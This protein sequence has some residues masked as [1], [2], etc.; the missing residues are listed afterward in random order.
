M[1]FL[2]PLLLIALPLIAMPIVIHLMNQ[3][4]HLVVPWAAM[5]F[6]RRA[7]RLNTGVAK[8]RYW[9]IM[10]MRMAAVTGVILALSRPLATG[11]V[12]GLGSN[13]RVTLIVLDR[14]P[15]MELQDTTTQMSKRM[16]AL[17]RLDTLFA[18]T[19]SLGRR[20]LLTS[21]LEKPL[22]ITSPTKLSGL[23]ETSSVAA[24]SDIP[25]LL[26]KAIAFADDNK[27]GAADI[28]VASDLQSGDWQPS[29]DRWRAIRE[30]V[31]KRP[32]T[33]LLLLNFPNNG[34]T[35]FSVSA[36]NIKPIEIDGKT[37]TSFDI[38]LHQNSGPLVRRTV[39]VLVRMGDMQST[40]EV[41]MQGEDGSVTGV[42]VPM[43]EASPSHAGMLE[44][45]PDANLADNQFHFVSQKTRSR[46]AVVVGQAS[47]EVDLL[48]LALSTQNDNS[49]Q[50]NL[51]SID[52][53]MLPTIDWKSLKLL[54]WNQGNINSATAKQLE[55]FIES[56][57]TLVLFPPSVEANNSSDLVLPF[58]LQ[59]S[60]MEQL[61]TAE[62]VESWRT[63]SD[64]LRNTEGGDALP[65]G[66][67]RW[68]QHWSMNSKGLIAL[69]KSASGKPLLSKL[70]TSYGQLFVC[71]TS[72]SESASN[73][74]EDGVCLYIMLQ[75]A[76]YDSSSLSDQSHWTAGMPIPFALQEWTPANDASQK[77][78]PWERS[79]QSGAY[80]LE[81]NMIAVNR[82]V[83]ED[84]LTSL[85]EKTLENM[86]QGVTY[87]SIVDDAG[88]PNSL[89]REIW[90]VF[91]VGMILF[92]LM[93]AWLSMPNRVSRASVRENTIARRGLAA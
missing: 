73:L 60:P 24:S 29:S 27:L 11:W 65:L 81:D 12:G 26:E 69:A 13:D 45:P 61:A 50:I 44:I 75:R 35:N 78:I 20:F 38:H 30:Q 53:T 23:P 72:V 19:R 82:A 18:T 56:G 58:G 70:P 42:R 62:R 41:T 71:H 6:L 64:L 14:S 9:L 46:S 25:G 67:I 91:I 47:E 3:R 39:P 84:T 17:E 59:W 48:A 57:G 83:T 40:V 88:K 36:T 21:G 77:V 68:N 7:K 31:I 22:E 37:E 89:A 5:Q 32:A 76:L 87:Q 93:E 28:W 63:D 43:E 90:R 34:D 49:P 10:A 33:R 66:E 2:Q 92:L 54:V 80:S 86:L 16:S 1:T 74:K 8:L 85:P 51:Q 79:I 55:S 4:R 15:S 52:S